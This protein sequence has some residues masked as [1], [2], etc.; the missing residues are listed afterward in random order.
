MSAM[1][2]FGAVAMLTAVAFALTTADRYARRGRVHELAWTQSMMMFAVASGAYWSAGAV[3]WTEWNFRLFYLFGAILNVPY[4]AVG[5]VAL[6]GGQARGR[7]VLTR[8]H[9]VAVFCAGIVLAAPLRAPMPAVGLPEGKLLFGPAPRVMAAVASGV[10]AT[11][12]LVGAIWSTRTLVAHRRRPLRGTAPIMSA[13][14]L[15]LTNVL[16]ATG[17]VV[18]SLGGLFFTGSDHE[19]AFG[20]FLVVGIAV[21][22]TGFMVSSQVRAVTVHP[23]PPESFDGYYRELWEIAHS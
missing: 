16:I 17:T 6:L 22:F 10:G 15:A 4:L 14:R 2:A 18:L 8:A 3:G 7:T 19:L 13:A 23:E 11:V 20:A 9:F 1:S 5:T 12:L 21:L